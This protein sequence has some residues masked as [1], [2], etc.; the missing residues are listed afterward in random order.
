MSETLLAQLN[1]GTNNA[2]PSVQPQ[3]LATA[4]AV[5]LE[6]PESI[7]IPDVPKDVLKCNN[8]SIW[9]IVAIIELVILA[10][11]GYQLYRLKG[12]SEKKH[13]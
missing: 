8:S 12:E 11:L 13:R 5:T 4:A 6:T 1:A 7:A 9:M 3:R 2:M 10:W